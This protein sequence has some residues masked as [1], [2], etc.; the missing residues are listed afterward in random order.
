M[1]QSLL[2]SYKRFFQFLK[3]PDQGSF[4]RMGTLFKTQTLLSL[5]LLNVV[6]TGL[7]LSGYLF[8]NQDILKNANSGLFV[9]NYLGVLA[10][11]VLIGPFLEELIFRLPMK[12][13]RNFLL[14]FLVYLMGLKRTDEKK[15]LLEFNVKKAW[16]KY[17]WIFF[18]VM[19]SI[20]AF[21][22]IFNYP[23]FKHLLLWSPILTC[24]QFFCGMI[25]GYTRIRFG[26]IW[27]WYY[28]ALHNMLVIFL[29][30]AFMGG[31]AQHHHTN[32]KNSNTPKDWIVENYDKKLDFTIEKSS[33]KSYLVTHPEF[34]LSIREG[35]DFNGIISGYGVTPNRIFFDR[36]S[37]EH[38]LQILSNNKIQVRDS[39]NLSLTV[40]LI[41]KSPQKNTDKARYILE[42][43][44]FKALSIK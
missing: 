9:F 24:T 1:Y 13:N 32:S 26:F 2:Q 31:F 22:H 33:F 16:R 27:G 40:E 41:M 12:Y 15:E 19:S 10:F 42:R 5:M 14:R 44:M 7:W 34:S 39:N 23:D 8:F 11:I 3:N 20:F 38:I 17:F 29:L 37:A 35:R 28:H 6:F 25:I 21:A 43:E 36:T 18:Y 30:M 4:K